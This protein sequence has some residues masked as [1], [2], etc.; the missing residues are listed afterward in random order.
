M[1][2]FC[3]YGYHWLLASVYPIN[4][5]SVQ[6]LP[7]LSI[8]LWEF[9]WGILILDIILQY[10]VYASFSCFS[11]VVKRYPIIIRIH[12]PIHVFTRCFYLYIHVYTYMYMYLSQL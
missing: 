9:I 1:S 11:Q 3:F 5:C 10:T 7:G 12:F 8:S 2:R 4:T 6:K